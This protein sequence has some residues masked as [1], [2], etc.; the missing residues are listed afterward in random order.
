V[1]GPEAGIVG[2]VVS[3]EVVVALQP[4]IPSISAAVAASHL[5]IASS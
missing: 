3:G 5:F 4:E 2:V 1:I